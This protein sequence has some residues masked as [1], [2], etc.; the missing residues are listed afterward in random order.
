M[1][2]VAAKKPRVSILH[3]EPYIDDYAWLR[4]RDAPEVL[5]HLDAENAHT[6]HVTAP[7]AGLWERIYQE[8][9]ARVH[10]ADE[11]LPVLDRGYYYYTRTEAGRQ[12]PLRCR[13][14]SLDGEEQILLDLDALAAGHG[15]LELDVFAVSDDGQRLA[16]S[17]D[18][19]GAREYTLRVL[20]L[21][22]GAHGPERIAGVRSAAWT[23]DHT[24]L[25]TVHD[26]TKRPYRLYRHAL[27]ASSADDA[28]LYEEHDARFRLRVW[29]ARSRAFLFVMSA[30]LTTTEVRFLPA[31]ARAA[32][33][34]LIAAREHGHQYYPDHAGDHFYIR[35]NDRGRGFRLV[36]APVSAPVSMPVSMP[37][38]A[39]WQELVP[40]R[41]QVT[42]SDVTVFRDFYV[43]TEREHG[44]PH[45]RVCHL[46]G[47]EG[48]RISMPDPVYGIA[49]HP[50]PEV[51]TTSFL[52][53]YQSLAT[54]DTVYEYDAARD[55]LTARKQAAVPGYE[56][57]RYRTERIHAT[58][59]D[60]ARV[61]I[62]LVYREDTPRDGTR[63]LLLHGYGAYGIAYPLAFHHARVSLLDRGVIVAVAHVRG[64]GE[65]GKPWHD[66]GRML[67]K[68]SSF[69]DFVAAAEHL[70]AGG[71][72]SR[73]RL[74]ASGGSAGGLLVSAAINM[75]PELFRVALSH[76][77]FVD[78]LNTML[79]ESLP[80]TVPEFEEWG[81]P[82]HPEHHAYIKRY[83]PYTNVAARPYPAMLVTASFHD[84]QVMYWEPA[85][86][87]AKL[88]A[89]TTSAE[90]ILLR[91]DMQGG[92]AGA[93]GRYDRLREIA[94]AYAFLLDRLAAPGR[95]LDGCHGA[96]EESPHER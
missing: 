44:L 39:R 22:T 21:R 69:T 61:P 29:R 35:T 40:H 6:A 86:Y 52:F 95:R 9:V 49:P 79:D 26:A 85:K 46:D 15:F 19:T 65:L 4:E 12:Y 2:P 59:P 66:G 63:P 54:P 71:Y 82:R 88:R 45:L 80:L 5:A 1:V 24:L 48:R 83:C 75:R 3:G 62:S 34:R 50:N 42:L 68:L 93:S 27:G 28:L 32:P 16:Y 14:R 55:A 23:D 30:S 84:S 11:S 70:I 74:A 73:E 87:V 31:G 76:V 67:H 58:A 96:V 56:R 60:G 36:R 25:Y 7:L 17:I 51:D 89:H 18:T 53:T 81:D 20:D 8:S 77:P 92:H 64:G 41:E 72:A 47:R 13:K 10:E 94:F 90:P 91:I 33:L 38:P 78:V 37:D 57:A 43:L